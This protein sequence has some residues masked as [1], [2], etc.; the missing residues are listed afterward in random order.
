M[1]K[2]RSRN[3][4]ERF[5]DRVENY[6]RFRP[7]YPEQIV[8]LI[9]RETALAPGALIADI[10]SGTGISSELFIRAG[11]R[12]AAVEPNKAMRAAAERQLA[13]SPGFRSVDGSAQA[14]TLETA[15][16]DLI[17]A[18]Q[19]FHWFDTPE[20]RAEFSRILKPG[21][22]IALIWNERK[23]DS[24]PFL[25]DYESL[26]LRFGMDYSEV[27]HENIGAESLGHF[28]IGPFSAHVFPN[29]QQFGFEALKG[30]MLSSSY[31]PTEGHPDY[32]PMIAELRGIFDRHQVSGNVD[33]L[34]D[35]RVYIGH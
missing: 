4:D 19:A 7:G 29:R 28:F 27:R 32:E 21:G 26:L 16:V 17:I 35:T 2:A 14:T 20:T 18:A 31:V 24:T 30:R 10:G 5:S 6:I 1:H 33:F 11:H 12:V 25:V 13:S 22:M 3:P 15:S 9:E 23:T 34:Y 8:A